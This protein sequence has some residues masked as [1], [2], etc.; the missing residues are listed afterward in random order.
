MQHPNIVKYKGFVKTREYLNIIL[1]YCENGSLQH[2]CKRFGKFPENLVGVYISQVLEGLMYLHDQGVIHRD[3]KG[4][5]ILTNKDGTVKLADFGVASASGVNDGAVVGSPYW[6]APEVIEQFG[7]TTASDIWSVGCVVIELLD[8]QPPYHQLKPMPA[9]FRIVQDDCPPIPDGAS[10]IVKD[11]LLHCF[12]KDPNL[13]ISAKKLLRHPWMVATRKQLGT[14]E[15]KTTEARPASNYGYDDAINRVL[16][17]NEALKSP[18]SPSKQL[19]SPVV[20]AGRVS[21]PTLRPFTVARSG[22]PMAIPS[23]SPV[24]VP[25]LSLSTSSLAAVAAPAVART[26]GVV[27]LA[28]TRLQ[29][30]V[31]APEEDTDNWDDDF[32][33]SE[34]DR[35]NVTKLAEKAPPVIPRPAAPIP[36]RPSLSTLGLPLAEEENTRTIR[37]SR[38]S[39]SSAGSILS[40]QIEPIVEDWTSDLGGSDATATEDD[41][42]TEMLDKVTKFKH[43]VGTGSGGSNSYGRGRRGIFHPDDIKTLGLHNSP[44]P[45]TAPLPDTDSGAS[46]SGR[47]F[48]FRETSPGFPSSPRNG[49]SPVPRGSPF[50]TST[51]ASGSGSLGKRPGPSPRGT[52]SRS[53]SGYPGFSSGSLGHADA[54]RMSTGGGVSGSALVSPTSESLERYT[55]DED[56][57]DY[58][59]VFAK[60]LN[61]QGE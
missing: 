16:E 30:T 43:R 12:Q 4:A 40:T 24:L 15:Q 13:R 11:F 28:P 60:P 33:M 46:S 38:S 14:G 22:T 61:G 36:I 54:R 25:S 3:I 29:Q 32:D 37:P 57:E 34:G 56:D 27:A 31:V 20:A 5:N 21:R 58:D 2:I 1:E 7:A 18:R 53:G 39:S 47:G 55:E 52:Q 51:S 49:P 48:P 19:Q 6:M 41:L 42:D 8:G 35:I 26:S 9:L 50:A 23:E 45:M 17:W 10:P 44:G 59:V